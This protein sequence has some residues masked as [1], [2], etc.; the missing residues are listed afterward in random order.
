[1]SASWSIDLSTFRSLRNATT[2]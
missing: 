1:M 2:S